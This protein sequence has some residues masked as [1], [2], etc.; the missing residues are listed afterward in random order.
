M[1]YSDYRV[2]IK[3]Y[4]SFFTVR[5]S[6]ILRSH[7]QDYYIQ[8]SQKSSFLL[9]KIFEYVVVKRKIVN[10]FDYSFKCK[11]K[12]GDKD[13]ESIHSSTTPDAGYHMGK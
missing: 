4:I 1:H 5:F 10:Y 2:V 13:Q 6:Q 11:S 8:I 12:K 9:P 7:S 3:K